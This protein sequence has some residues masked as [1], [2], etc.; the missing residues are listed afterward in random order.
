MQNRDNVERESAERERDLGS[1]ETLE[2]K[3]EKA[4]EEGGGGGG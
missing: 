1:S 3:R 2:M 4:R